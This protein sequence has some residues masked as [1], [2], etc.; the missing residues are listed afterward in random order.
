MI[1]EGIASGQIALSR[2]VEDFPGFI[3]GISG[4]ELGQN[5]YEQAE[6]L[7]QSLLTIQ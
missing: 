1:E 7:A 6:R 4:E 3:K 5:M 2:A